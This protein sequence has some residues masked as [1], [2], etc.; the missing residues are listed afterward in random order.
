MLGYKTVCWENINLV[1]YIYLPSH[2]SELPDKTFKA[3]ARKILLGAVS[4]LLDIIGKKKKVSEKKNQTE[5]LKMKT[6][7]T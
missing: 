7:T 3:T 6:V 2:L 5:S 1:Y 4:N